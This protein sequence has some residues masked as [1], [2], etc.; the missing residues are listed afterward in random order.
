MRAPESIMHLTVRSCT[1]TGDDRCRL[2][3]IERFDL[4]FDSWS[5]FTEQCDNDL[6]AIMPNAVPSVYRRGVAEEAQA[7]LSSVDRTLTSLGQI[8]SRTTAH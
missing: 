5:I 7:R 4:I 3:S 8:T 1:S 2:T 6:A